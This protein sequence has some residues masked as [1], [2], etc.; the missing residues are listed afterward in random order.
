M[1]KAL[2]LSAV[3]VA[4]LGVV[5][6]GGDDDEEDTG[7]ATTPATTEAAGGDGGGGAAGGGQTLK[8]T[9]DSGG[10][11]E[12]APTQLNA[13]AGSVTIEL[14][15]PSSTPHNVEVEGGGIEEVSD[16]IT[17]ST[18]SVT[19]DLQAGEYVY[20]CNVPGHRDAGMEGTLTVE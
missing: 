11:L 9:A 15:N 1:K 17:E 10:S 16:T 4:S 3:I 12:W 6:C 2:A 19:V 20:Y 5:A 18:A 7:A 8:V 13:Q 14:D